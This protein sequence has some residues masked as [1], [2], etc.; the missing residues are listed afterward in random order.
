MTNVGTNQ[1]GSYAV[2]VF[3]RTGSLTSSNAILTVIPQPGL[4]L[5]VLA[6]YPALTLSGTLGSRFL[7]QYNTNLANM[8]WVTLLC[9]TNLSASPYQ[10]LDPSGLGQSERFYR[11]FFSQ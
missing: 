2:E 4:S 6:G 5:K 11:A 7:V 10:F 9:I 8:A 3:N 1:A